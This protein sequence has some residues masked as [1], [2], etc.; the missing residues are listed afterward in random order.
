MCED[1]VDVWYE[2]VT[3]K[4]ANCASTGNRDLGQLQPGQC[5]AGPWSLILFSLISSVLVN[6]ST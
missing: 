6:K 3:Y 2:A 4:S 1:E 5:V